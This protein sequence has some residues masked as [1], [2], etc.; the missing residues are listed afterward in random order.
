MQAVTMEDVLE[1]REEHSQAANKYVLDSE[2]ARNTHK[3]YKRMIRR[4][5]DLN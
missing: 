3:L 5:E 1:K 4:K 2:Q